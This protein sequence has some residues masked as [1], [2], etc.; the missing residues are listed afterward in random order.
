MR[1]V[2][3][4]CVQSVIIVGI[5]LSLCN[6]ADQRGTQKTTHHVIFSGDRE[7]RRNPRKFGDKRRYPTVN[8]LQRQDSQQSSRLHGLE[9]HKC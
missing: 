3:F 4:E 7:T 6:L 1:D 9:I 5:A 8:P 2:F